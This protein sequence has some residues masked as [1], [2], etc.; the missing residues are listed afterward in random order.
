MGTDKLYAVWRKLN[1]A[2]RPAGPYATVRVAEIASDLDV[3]END[4]E[5]AIMI[6]RSRFGTITFLASDD[7]QRL[8][9]GSRPRKDCCILITSS[10]KQIMLT[11]LD[12]GEAT[13][14]L[15]AKAVLNQ[16]TL[17]AA[18]GS[19]ETKKRQRA[20]EDAALLRDMLQEMLRPTTTSEKRDRETI[21]RSVQHEVWR[22]DNG[23]CVYCGER[24]KLHFDHIIPVSKGG[25]STARNVQLLCEGCNLAKRDTI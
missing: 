12:A 15:Q 17:D 5:R 11:A 7:L 3:A 14:V 8:A 23:Q 22:R 20:E 6:H 10:G 2:C 25:S 19:I 18:S 24:E 9:N 21:P 1:E 13:G 4:V 16:R